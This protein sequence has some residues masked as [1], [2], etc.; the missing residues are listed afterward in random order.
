MRPRHFYRGIEGGAHRYLDGIFG[1]SMR[2][3]HFYRGIAPWLRQPIELSPASMRPRHFYRGIGPEALGA[4]SCADNGASMRPRHFYRGIDNFRCSFDHATASASM[5][6]RHFYRGID[7][8]SLYA[9][10]NRHRFNEAPAF[11]PGN[12]ARRWFRPSFSKL[13]LQ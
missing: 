11:L 7:S 9:L 1:A 8:G 10:T 13:P 5:R 12:S 3:R 6:P 4:R 2:P